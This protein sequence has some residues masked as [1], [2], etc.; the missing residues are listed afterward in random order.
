MINAAE[1][2]DKTSEGRRDIIGFR[3]IAD[4]RFDPRRAAQL[5]VGADR[6]KTPAVSRD[7]QQFRALG[8]VEARGGLSDRRGRAKHDHSHATLRQKCDEKPGSM[9]RPN[10][11]QFGYPARNISAGMRPSFAA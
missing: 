6:G 4:R 3:E 8:G 1:R 2:V 5:E 9:W 10:S 11:R 7:K